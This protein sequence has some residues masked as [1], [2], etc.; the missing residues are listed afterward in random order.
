MGAA[1]FSD[2]TSTGAPCRN[3]VFQ[4]TSPTRKPSAL[5]G[6]VMF[7]RMILEL[8]AHKPSAAPFVRKLPAESFHSSPDFRI[9][10][11]GHAT[12]LA[13][14]GGVR[15]LMDPIFSDRCSPFPKA[16]PKR[17]HD[18]PIAAV[19]LPP[20]DAVIISHDHYDHLDYDTIMAIKDKTGCFY[21]PRNVGAHLER[22]GIPRRKIIEAD[23]WEEK[24][25]GPSI[26]LA[27]APARHFSGRSVS[28]MNR[29]LWASWV[30][31]A[32][33]HRIFF[34]GDS[35]M[36]P[37]FGMIGKRFG[38]FDVALLP[39]GGYD[40]RRWPDIHMTPEQ[41]VE[42]ARELQGALILPIHWCTFDIS[43]HGWAEPAERL[44]TAAGRAGVPLAIP[45][46]G[47]PFTPSGPA[48][49]VVPWWR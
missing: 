25:L 47:E 16:G 31:I 33:G 44:L 22:W 17:L 43:F 26:T 10:W 11:M 36:M 3:G 6:T 45:R 19:E 27:A 29:T 15:I 37:E 2:C 5:A 18:V 13:E 32:P 21:V 46:P 12:I 35:G 14:I 7:W 41:A 1:R 24:K 4:N 49:A 28:G 34:C 39:I 8:Q 23:W 9:T 42:A 40:S 48:P 30:I 20:L 38:P